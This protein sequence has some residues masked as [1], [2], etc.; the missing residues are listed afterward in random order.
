MQRRDVVA[1][2]ETFLGTPYRHQ[3]SRRGVG[4]DCLGL[5]RGIWRE[6]YGREPEIAGPYTPDWAER[7]V[8]EPLLEAARRHFHDIRQEEAEPGDLLVF[9]WRTGVT[10]KHCGILAPEGRLIHAYEGAAV[11]SSPLGSAWIRRTAGAFRFPE[12]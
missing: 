5:V 2:A 6:L 9:R 1:A 3:G 8:G 10:A 4:C 12:A 7:T 11:V